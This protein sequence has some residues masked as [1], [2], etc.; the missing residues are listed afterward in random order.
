MTLE[1]TR[2]SLRHGLAVGLLGLA[3]CAHRDAAVQ[4]DVPQAPVPA[5]A[6]APPSRLRPLFAATDGPS[7]FVAAAKLGL[8]IR[9]EEA[10]RLAPDLCGDEPYRPQGFEDVRLSAERDAYGRVGALVMRL[11]RASALA[12]VMRLWGQPEK[13]FDRSAMSS[14]Y[15][16]FD[17][18][19]RIRAR[20]ENDAD[21]N[22]SRLVIE[23]YWPI[24]E[25]LGTGSSHVGFE[26]EPLLGMTQKRATE[27]YGL[28]FPPEPDGKAPPGPYELCRSELLLLAPVEY[29]STP[30]RVRVRCAHGSVTSYAIS[31]RYGAFFEQR[32]KIIELLGRKLGRPAN[33]TDIMGRTVLD[34]I[35]DSLHVRFRYDEATKDSIIEVTRGAAPPRKDH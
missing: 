33:K 32:D 1:S 8:G 13:G 29:D 35:G 11:P 10:Q 17:D 27:I 15:W 5:R 9:F 30:T 21:P 2:K 19:S 25:L 26:S 22:T 16:W 24:S 12:D 14:L 3:A 28:H 18:D 31:I 20:L 7:L 4:L 6:P 23:R 34:Y